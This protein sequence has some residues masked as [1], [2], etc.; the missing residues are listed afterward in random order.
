[1]DAPLRAIVL[2]FDGVIVES[3]VIKDRA[4]EELYKDYPAQLPAIMAYHRAHNA[5]IRFEKFRFIAEHILKQPYSE[6]LQAELSQKFSQL[7]VQK[8]I[9]CPLVHGVKEFLEFFFQRVPLYLATINP[10]G[11]LTRIL[12]RK[13][14]E[15]FF[16]GIYAVPW[17]KTEALREIMRRGDLDPAEV[18]F[19]GDSLEDYR[20]AS[21]AGVVFVGR[22]PSHRLKGVSAPVFADLADIKDYFQSHVPSLTR[23][24]DEIIHR[25]ITDYYEENQTPEHLVSSH[26]KQ[27][28]QRVKIHKSAN[29]LERLHGEGFGDL[30][31]ASWVYRVCSWATMGC[32]LVQL[33]DRRRLTRLM[34]QG[35]ELARRMGLNFTYDCFRQLCALALIQK[36]FARNSRFNVLNIGDGYGFFSGM[37]KI[38]FPQSRIFM[39]DL[40]KTLLFQARHLTR[41]FPGKE[42][43]LWEQKR[44]VDDVRTA[45]FVFVPAEF[46]DA[47]EGL[48]FDLAINIASMQ[49]MNAASVARYF[50]F[51]RRNL[52]EDHLFYCGNR[53]EK[54]MPSGEVSRFKEYPWKPKDLHFVDGPVPWHKYFFTTQKTQR[55]LIL[56]GM[57][58]PFIGYFD[59]DN[60]HRLSRLELATDVLTQGRTSK[61]GNIS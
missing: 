33:S 26:W 5:I 37:I 28:H 60:W 22:D 7:V 36:N 16:S 52:S 25:L 44:S 32:Y 11:D 14:L 53:E 1:M 30:E 31:N 56:G 19:V 17:K 40:G 51:L 61:E 2:D 55:G 35:R 12:K 6:H 18:A 49:E 48:R 42:H 20:S 27:F 8:T 54:I 45:D 38:V 3:V 59:G 21:E 34:T 13:G 58:V 39:V 9:D 41:A 23:R 10:V 57:R 29:R 46:L 43:Q 24:H 4:F 47:L 15:K 50:A